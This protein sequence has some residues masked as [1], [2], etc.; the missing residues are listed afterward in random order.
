VCEVV[1][2]SGGKAGIV[3]SIKRTVGRV[4]DDVDGGLNTSLAQLFC[5]L[6]TSVSQQ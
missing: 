5:R 3:A 1:R 6:M 2:R 4:A